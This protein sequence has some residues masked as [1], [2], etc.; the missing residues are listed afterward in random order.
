MRLGTTMEATSPWVTVI[1]AA[2]AAFGGAPLFTFLA[3]RIKGQAAVRR[4]DREGL[5]REREDLKAERRKLEEYRQRMVEN[6]R[7][8]LRTLRGAFNEVVE[9]NGRLQGMLAR[10]D[11][12]LED[13][14][15]E[16]AALRKVNG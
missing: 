9:T 4:M 12:E 3:E 6:D 14:R 2:I 7:L 16:L 15:A 5:E 10:A 1:V 11:E 13:L 8:E